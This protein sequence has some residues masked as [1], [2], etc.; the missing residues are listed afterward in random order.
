MVVP[1]LLYESE[2]CTIRKRDM[3]KL[4]TA[5]MRFIRSVNGYKN[6]VKLGMNI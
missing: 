2:C 1:A 6:W 4:K 3:Q 5:E